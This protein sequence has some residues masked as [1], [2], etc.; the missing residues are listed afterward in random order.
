M[1]E[2][3]T[4]YLFCTSTAKQVQNS[5]FQVS[6]C[7]PDTSRHFGTKYTPTQI[8]AS[9]GKDKK[10]EIEKENKIFKLSQV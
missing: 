9:F 7:S 10:I 4:A 2:F 3:Q 1:S 8:G 6:R 5:C